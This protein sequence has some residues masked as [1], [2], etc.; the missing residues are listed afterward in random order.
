MSF[1]KCVTTTYRKDSYIKVNTYIGKDGKV[2]I[3]N[4]RLLTLEK[5]EPEKLEPLTGQVSR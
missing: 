5:V 2:Y 4:K 1:K 3:F